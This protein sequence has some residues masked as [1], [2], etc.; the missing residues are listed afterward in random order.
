[1]DQLRAM[2]TFVK[3]VDAGSLTAAADRMGT[4]LAAVVRS[5]AGLERHLGLRLLNRTTRRMALTDDGAEYL[6]H[7]RRL[8]ADIEEAE[9]SLS[10]RRRIPTGTLRL[11]A[12]VM[13]GRMHVAPLATA[14][15]EAHAGVQVEMTLLDRVVDL[16]EEGLDLAVRVGPL[17][18]SS[19]VSV[20]VG[21]TRRMV[22]ASPAYLAEHGHPLTLADL[23]G[24]RCLRFTGTA[25]VADW[26]F[27]EG[28]RPVRVAVG[29]PLTCNQ[30]DVAI[31]ACLQ[32]LGCG[33]F[34]EYQVRSLLDDGRLVA[35]L[36]SFEGPAMP[37]WMIYPHARL[38]SSRVRAFVDWAVPR[39][40]QRLG[41]AS[42]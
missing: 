15:L 41:P 34:L 37:V 27:V 22:C 19:L 32:G 23:E 14:F 28:G 1:M 2:A 42:P 12:P 39:L 38:L 40:R 36:E 26:E 8:L 16:L 9:A 18:D 20:R 31:D 17:A 4:S 6:A 30:V 29:G 13:L 21:S 11:T 33:R 5:L 3:I 7:C 25:Q 10:L 35:L 24:H